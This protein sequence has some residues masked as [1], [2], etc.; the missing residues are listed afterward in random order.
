MK[1]IIAGVLLKRDLTI[2]V[3]T[4]LY[5]FGIWYNAELLNLY[6]N[7]PKWYEAGNISIANLHTSNRGLLTEIDLNKI[8]N[9]KTNFFK[10]HRVIFIYFFLF[11]FFLLLSTQYRSYQ[12]G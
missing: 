8:Y 2:R 4:Y 3:R 9:V 10:Y 12:Y 5:P 7:C 1:L 6:L 11:G